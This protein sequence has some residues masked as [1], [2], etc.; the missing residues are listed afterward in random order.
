MEL[1]LGSSEVCVL[2]YF[3]VQITRIWGFWEGGK[4]L[5]DMLHKYFLSKPWIVA[6]QTE[7]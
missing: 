6:Y 5:W 7:S 2:I 3:W 1:K 4:L